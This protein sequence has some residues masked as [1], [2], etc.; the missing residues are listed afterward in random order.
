MPIT[1]TL[2]DEL[3]AGLENQARKQQLSVE[4]FA[5]SVLTEA[6]E[7]SESVT[8]REAATRIQA[9]TPNPS[10]VRLATSNMADVLRAA[11]V[12]PCFDPENW[13]R[14]W[15]GIEAE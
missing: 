3:V 9:T 12:D 7:E 15:A 14:Q 5:I 10:Q 1:I 13:K 6:S 8:P 4:Q 2:D 11:P